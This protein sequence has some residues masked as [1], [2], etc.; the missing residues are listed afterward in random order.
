MSVSLPPTVVPDIS[1]ASPPR[2]LRPPPPSSVSLPPTAASDMTLASPKMILVVRTALE[3]VV[4]A[5]RRA[6]HHRGVAEDD[7]FKVV[8]VARAAEKGVVSAH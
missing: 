1:K 7:E 3:P 5:R 8:A 4:A 6:G 2:P